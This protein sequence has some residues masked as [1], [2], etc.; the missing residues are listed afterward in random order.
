MERIA[1]RTIWAGSG[2]RKA[3]ALKAGYMHCTPRAGFADFFGPQN[4]PRVA[5][6]VTTPENAP[7]RLRQAPATSILAPLLGTKIARKINE[8]TAER[9]RVYWRIARR[10][11]VVDR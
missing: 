3:L 5:L 2:L 6:P 11:A 1:K 7:K 9:R 8:L 4:R 10:I